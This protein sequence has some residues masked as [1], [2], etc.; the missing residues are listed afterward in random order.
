MNTANLGLEGLCLAI[1]SVNALLV[2]KGLVSHAEMRE[3]LE[4]AGESATAKGEHDDLS[5]ANRK[6]ICFPI[7]FLMLANEKTEKQETVRFRSVAEEI[8]R[9][10]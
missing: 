9:R 10:W 1:A 8:G 2:E 3:A 6:A 4:R 7:R 5:E